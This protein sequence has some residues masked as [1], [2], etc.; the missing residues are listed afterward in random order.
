VTC[1]AVEVNVSA[2]ETKADYFPSAYAVAGN[3]I[4]YQKQLNLSVIQEISLCRISI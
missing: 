4:G 2:L 3:G 1:F